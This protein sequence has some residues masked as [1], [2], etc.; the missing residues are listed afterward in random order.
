VFRH[1]IKYA[2]ILLGHYGKKYDWQDDLHQT[3]VDYIASMT[4]DYFMAYAEHLFPEA[5]ELFPR[6]LHF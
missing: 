3:V 6:R 2:N 5:V 1:H 4:D